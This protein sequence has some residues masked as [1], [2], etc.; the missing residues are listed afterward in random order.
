MTF[1]EL[2]QQD[3]P[4]IL[5]NVWD[6]KSAQTAEKLNF[7]AVGTSSSALANSLGYEDGEHI[8]FADLLFV[9]RHIVRS[10]SL[11]VSVDLEGGY[12]RD[13]MEIADH[14]AQLAE[15]GVVG[16]NFEDS[17]LQK[18]RTQLPAEAFAHTLSLVRSQLDKQGIEMFINLR[19]DAFLLKQPNATQESIT[20]IRLYESAGADGIF[21]PC[22]TQESDIQAIVEATTLPVN[23]LAFPGLPDFQALTDLGV[24][25]MSMG[26]FLFHDLYNTYEQML[27]TV[28]RD[29]Q[30]TSIF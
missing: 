22:I 1:K 17:V 24:K 12:S 6:A 13:P 9:V 30:F 3:G 21:V 19:T 2:H 28:R 18:S 27:V 15:I 29:Q 25:R 11:P 20:R 23:V 4:L 5:C 7:Q 26:G 14:M 8:R 10:T 16:V